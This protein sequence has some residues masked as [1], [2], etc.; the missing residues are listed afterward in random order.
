MTKILIVRAME[1]TQQCI[2]IAIKT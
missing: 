2:N 1:E